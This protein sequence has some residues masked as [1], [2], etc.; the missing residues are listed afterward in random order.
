MDHKTMML[1]ILVLAV[2]HI[3][4]SGMMVVACLSAK[5]KSMKK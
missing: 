4:V 2:A 5:D 3:L 1:I